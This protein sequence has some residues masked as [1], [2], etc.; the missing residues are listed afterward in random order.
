MREARS[1]RSEFQVAI[2]PGGG[3]VQHGHVGDGDGAV[4]SGGD[5]RAV[6]LQRNEDDDGAEADV[7]VACD[8]Y[9]G[10]LSPFAD[11]VPSP[12]FRVL[13]PVVPFQGSGLVGFVLFSWQLR[14]SRHPKLN[15]YEAQPNCHLSSHPACRRPREEGKWNAA[16]RE[17]EDG[18]FQKS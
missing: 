13:S 1:H 16:L 3:D 9:G 6:V 17:P 14:L 18:G 15:L 7:G 5:A 10:R 2:G 12:D 11:H 4:R 8:A